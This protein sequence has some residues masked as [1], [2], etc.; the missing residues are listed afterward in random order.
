MYSS[1]KLKG[2]KSGKFKNYSSSLVGDLG[3][4]YL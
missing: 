2:D 3:Q 1:T 4:L